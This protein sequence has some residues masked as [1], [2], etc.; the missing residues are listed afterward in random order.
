MNIV[1]RTNMELRAIPTGMHT[2]MPMAIPMQR[3]AITSMGT[4][5]TM[6]P[7][8]IGIQNKMAVSSLFLRR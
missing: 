1:M 8:S 3:Q 7:M 4:P 2:N 5:A 6:G